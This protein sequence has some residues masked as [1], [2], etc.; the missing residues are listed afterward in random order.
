LNLKELGN[1]KNYPKIEWKVM[2]SSDMMNVFNYLDTYWGF[3]ATL[4]G[5]AT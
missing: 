2:E 4:A 5:F 1:Q 3:L